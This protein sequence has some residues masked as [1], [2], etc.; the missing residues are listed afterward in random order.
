MVR[1]Q[2]IV[3]RFVPW[4]LL[5]ALLLPLTPS[6][7]RANGIEILCVDQR[8]KRLT[9]DSVD[10][11][12]RDLESGE[13]IR[14]AVLR[15]GRAIL[16]VPDDRGVSVQVEEAGLWSPPIVVQSGSS[17]PHSVPCL[18]TGTLA[19]SVEFVG[20][21]A[22]RGD[23]PVD[24]RLSIRFL[25]QGS[26]RTMAETGASE[27]RHP[28]GTVDCAVDQS[29]AFACDLPGGVLDLRARVPSHVSEYLWNVRVTPGEVT[30][31]GTLHL[32]PGASLSGWV[33]LAGGGDARDVLVS[34]QPQAVPG[35]GERDLIDVLMKTVSASPNREGFFHVEGVSPGGYQLEATHPQYAPAVVG[36]HVLQDREASLQTPLLLT[37]AL[38]V[39]IQV[40]PATAPG[41]QPWRI[42]LAPEHPGGVRGP[43][44]EAVIA[45]ALGF[46]T[47]PPLARGE[48]KLN[49]GPLDAPG[50]KIWLQR[51]IDLN[52]GGGHVDVRVPF[53]RV[54]GTVTLA[55]KPVKAQIF[56]G[57]RSGLAGFVTETDEDGRFGGIVARDGRWSVT[58][59]E[60]ALGIERTV[61]VELEPNE[62]G[63]A[64]LEVELPDTRVRGRT[65]DSTGQPVTGAIVTS[66]PVVGGPSSQV[67][68][69]DNGSF[70]LVGIDE[71]LIFLGAETRSLES[72]RVVLA[73]GEG[74][75]PVV[76]LVLTERVVVR[77]MVRTAR[78][79]PVA[80]GQV[81]VW[82]P[83]SLIQIAQVPTGHD[84]RFEVAVRPGRGP[85]IVTV[86]APSFSAHS[87]LQELESGA[88]IV[89][90][91]AGGSLSISG[92][93]EWGAGTSLTL[94]TDAQ[95][96]FHHVDL[97]TMARINHGVLSPSEIVVPMLPTG[98]SMLCVGATAGEVRRALRGY[99]E[100][101]RCVPVHV[102]LGS[103]TSVHVPS[104]LEPP[105]RR[106][107]D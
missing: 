47:T 54:E 45:D 104:F 44:T 73:V 90:H 80:G 107:D 42:T 16:E 5:T 102:S 33:V 22:D 18:P 70:E 58:V 2:R 75:R 25:P 19:G 105:N 85:V 68:S 13:V 87:A 52:D 103:T 61:P 34:L 23:V 99:P 48:Y 27:P 89:L 21:G 82:D 46:A 7:G 98:G 6:A 9:R 4:A 15:S 83:N 41:D 62:D 14:S 106:S 38:Q 94:L 81:S 53:I 97:E 12:V 28:H 51:S 20:D 100:S 30:R 77:A 91:Q 76:E 1:Q 49:V 84:G 32:K 78:G 37:E 24:R 66:R 69:Q 96:L 56:F 88:D 31:L 50:G 74:N 65:I 10:L 86:I 67:F 95:G 64:T 39:T 72:E 8:G 93:D 35:R 59:Q 36:V 92:L 60:M 63:L 17:Q 55:A 79:D 11:T 3:A 40:S 57:G 26:Q 101:S 43:R 71:G 29:W